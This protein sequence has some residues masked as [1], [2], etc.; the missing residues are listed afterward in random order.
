LEG[1]GVGASEVFDLQAALDRVDGD[2]ALFREIVQMFLTDAAGRM[3]EVQEAISGQDGP[4][5]E[6]AT[7]TLK[8]SVGNFGAQR[9]YAAAQALEKKGR[10]QDFTDIETAYSRL[11][12]EMA[13]FV[14]ALAPF[15]EEIGP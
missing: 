6:R 7:H 13:R 8:G 3:A 15:R 5:L 10:S 11:E 1:L 2:E 12:D 9:V 4:A 14:Q